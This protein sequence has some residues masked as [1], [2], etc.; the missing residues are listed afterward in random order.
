M[1]ATIQAD[2]MLVVTAETGLEAFALHHW[3]LENIGADWFDVTRAPAPKIILDA[4][5]FRGCMGM[6]FG[7][8]A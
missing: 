3:S 1:K 4:S 8:P 2:G 5:E 6:P 7:M